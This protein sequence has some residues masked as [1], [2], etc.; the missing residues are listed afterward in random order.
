MQK[1]PPSL[2]SHD[3]KLRLNSRRDFLADVGRG[4]L[5]SSVGSTLAFDLALAP[6]Y[7]DEVVGLLSFG[8]LEPLVALIQHRS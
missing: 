8:T 6:A 1:G 7:A 4:M 2:H 5:I 3:A